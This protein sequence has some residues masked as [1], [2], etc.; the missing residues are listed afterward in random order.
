MYRLDQLLSG[1]KH[2][3]LVLRELNRYYFLRFRMR[4]F[5]DAGV[6]IFTED[7]DTLVILDACRYDVFRDQ[8]SI[9]GRLESRESKASETV[10]FLKANFDGRDLRDTVYVTANPQ[11]YRFRSEIETTLHDIVHV[12]RDDGWDDTLGTVRPEKT[13]EY[14]L[15]AAESYPAKRLIV[16]YI[17]PHYPFLDT[18]TEFDKGHLEREDDEPNLW[19]RKLWGELDVDRETLWRLYVDNLEATLPQVQRLLD[20]ITGRTIVTAD[21]GNMFGERSFP[22][23]IREWGHPHST[24][25]EELVHVPWLVIDDGPRRS[26]TADEPRTESRAVDADVSDRLN[27]LGYIS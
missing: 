22:I 1:V 26:I 8:N 2:P 27:Q 16:H 18:N 13:T 15:N 12:W 23:P 11:L 6:D 17:Q 10:G 19:Y 4:Q 5:N 7:W 14:A 3:S 9:A 25:T 20:G 21:H 24:F